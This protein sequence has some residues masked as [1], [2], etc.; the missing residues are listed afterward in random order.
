MSRP[1]WLPSPSTGLARPNIASVRAVNRSYCAGIW[2]MHC[3][4]YVG[5]APEVS[6]K[7]VDNGWLRAPNDFVDGVHIR[8]GKL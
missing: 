8:V 1:R 5:I 7:T 4:R 2:T 6:D 3:M